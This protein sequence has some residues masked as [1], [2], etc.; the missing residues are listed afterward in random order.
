[1]AIKNID[2]ECVEKGLYKIKF[3]YVDTTLNGA[4]YYIYKVAGWKITLQSFEGDTQIEDLT[5]TWENR[6][7]R[8]NQK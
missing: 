2:V 6:I 8:P 5:G 1:M 3:K 7:K 4:K